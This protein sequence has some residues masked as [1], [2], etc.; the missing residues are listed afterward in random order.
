VSRSITNNKAFSLLELIIAIAILSVGITAVLQAVSYST[1]VA[2]LS[3]D[4]ISAVMLAEDNLQELEYKESNKLLSGEAAD[5]SG[6]LDRFNWSRTLEP[7][8][9]LDLYRLKFSV[10]WQKRNKQEG[11]TV[12]TYLRK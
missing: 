6:T 3:C 2:G 10:N 4:M 9:D 12:D 11:F 8:E 5:G 7:E 1:S